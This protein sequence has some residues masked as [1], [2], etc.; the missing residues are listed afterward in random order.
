[1]ISSFT[2]PCTIGSIRFQRAMIDLGASIKVF[3]FSIFASLNLGPLKETSVILQLAD[4]S[5]SKGVLKDV[6]V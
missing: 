4:R 3:P 1:M 2:I 5:N 6:L